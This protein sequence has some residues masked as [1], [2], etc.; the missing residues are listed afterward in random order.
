VGNFFSTNSI[1]VITSLLDFKLESHQ[2][3]ALSAEGHF[4]TEVLR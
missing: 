3:V 2:E 4:R 1:E